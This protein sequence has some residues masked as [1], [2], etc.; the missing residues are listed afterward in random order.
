MKTN[1][2]LA[3]AVLAG[4]S[5][6]VAAAMAIQAQVKTPPGYV[7]AEVDATDTAAMQKYGEK[8]PETLKHWCLSLTTISFAATRSRLLKANR[9]RAALWSSLSTARTRRARGTTRQLTPRSG[10]S[11]KAQPRAAYLSSKALPPSLHCHKRF[12]RRQE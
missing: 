5:I 8:V 6:G 11:G 2:K 9:P 1:H 7:I 12:T 10:R 3:A 4:V